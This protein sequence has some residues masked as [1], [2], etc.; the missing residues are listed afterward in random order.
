MIHFTSDTHFYHKN[1]I[2]FC[3]WS[4][5]HFADY[6]EMNDTLVDNWNS[7][8][9]PDDTVY[10][11]GDFIFAGHVK[12]ISILERLNGNIVLCTGNHDQVF[13]PALRERLGQAGLIKDFQPT[14]YELRTQVYGVKQKFILNHYAQRVWNSHHHGTI[15]LY[16]HSHGSLPGVGKS[17]DVGVDSKELALFTGSTFRPWSIKEI[18]DY[19]ATRPI[20]EADHHASPTDEEKQN[21]RN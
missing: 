13:K 1:I 19:M 4:R 3:P 10:H 9:E 20:H 21:D 7:V 17:V 18:V 8:V 16:G 15:H 2:K 5:G 14:Y 11:L 12:L 6:K